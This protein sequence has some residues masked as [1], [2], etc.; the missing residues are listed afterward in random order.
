[1]YHLNKMV[2]NRWHY[3]NLPELLLNVESGFYA[4]N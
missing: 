3:D 2:L 1:M 4:F